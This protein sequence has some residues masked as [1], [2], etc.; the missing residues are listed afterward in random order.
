M[1]DST[2]RGSFVLDLT[3][4]IEAVGAE[5]GNYVFDDAER[6]SGISIT[7]PTSRDGTRLVPALIVDALADT[8]HLREGDVTEV[9]QMIENAMLRNLISLRR[10][11][12]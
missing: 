7:V 5:I 9:I 6:V 12:D 4:L 10:D 11:G 1:R 8:E 3:G 2:S